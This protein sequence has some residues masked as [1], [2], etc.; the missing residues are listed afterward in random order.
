LGLQI[1]LNFVP[2]RSPA[3]AGLFLVGGRVEFFLA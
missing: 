3:K 2:A 1:G